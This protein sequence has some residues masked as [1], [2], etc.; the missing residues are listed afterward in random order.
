MNPTTESGMANETLVGDRSRE[1]VGP[2][3]VQRPVVQRPLEHAGPK[4]SLLR[5]LVKTTMLF[6][7]LIA[8][9][10][11]GL[12]KMRVNIPALKTSEVYAQI[13]SAIARG[14]HMK[15]YVVGKYES[16]FPK[17]VVE[18]AHHEEHK[19]VVTRPL[20][21]DVTITQDYV[22]QI[23]SQ[24]HIE[25]R[26]L[27]DGYLEAI[28]IKEGQAVKAG[29]LMFQIVPVLYKAELAA[30]KA[31][32][33]LGQLELDYTTTLAAKQGV[34]Q[35]EVQLYKAKLARAQAKVDLAQAKLDFAAV[36]A[37]FDGI[38]DRLKEQQGSLVKEGD[39]LTT[40]SDNSVMWVYFNVPEK[41]Y[42]EYMAEVGQ[43]K[44]SSDIILMLADHNKFPQIGKIDLAHNIGAIAANFNN[45]NGNIAF[46]ADFPNPNRLLRHGQTGTVLIHRALKDAIVIPQRATFE[47]LAKRYVYV[48]DKEHV[49]H[50]R[51]IVIDHELDDI[52]IIGKGLSVD[53][54]IVL[55]GVRQVHDG[56]KVEFEFL[57]PELA[58]KDQKNHA[59]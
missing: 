38:I 9:G 13:D 39:I 55:E 43:N 18:E 27:D 53:D 35:K 14:E 21:K 30:E 8:G 48:I 15:G 33:D 11:F 57:K 6:A 4:K 51:E 3:V 45:E 34:S 16:Y 23:H 37:P 1:H 49:A 31:E 50:Q 5:R 40:L 19:L 7:A 41:R 28:S 47:N 2:P 52:F 36:K 17:H 24:R 44:Q 20:A 25:V 58:I 22:C 56:A 26:A 42:L 10:V 54:Q 59:E 12:Y 32:R 29:D 46:R